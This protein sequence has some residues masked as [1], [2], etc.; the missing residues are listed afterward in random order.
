[1]KSRLVAALLALGQATAASAQTLDAAKLDL[2]FDGL[3]EKNKEF[4]Q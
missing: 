1:V 4:A 2:L 3:L